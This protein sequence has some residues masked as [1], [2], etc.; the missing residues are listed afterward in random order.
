MPEG[1]QTL[2]VLGQ[3]KGI[4]STYKV[5]VEDQGDNMA[6][7]FTPDGKTANPTLKLYKGQ[8]YRF[9]V[10]TPNYPI[11]FVT[12]VSFTPGREPD[13]ETTNTSLI[14]YWY[15]FYLNT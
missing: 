8:T 4:T 11:A 12:K 10:D 14:Y 2:T 9:V 5:T 1:P 6:F 15:L 3:A 7:V 13:T